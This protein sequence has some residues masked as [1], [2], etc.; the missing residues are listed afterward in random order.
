MG[1]IFM[2]GYLNRKQANSSKKLRLLG[3]DGYYLMVSSFSSDFYR[4]NKQ[5]VLTQAAENISEGTIKDNRG[6]LTAGLCAATI[7]SWKVPKEFGKC[8]L[9]S[10]T[11]FLYEYPEICTPQELMGVYENG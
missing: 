5:V 4:A 2:E 8:T 10:A 9:E 1:R 6:L 11:K 7:T 3:G